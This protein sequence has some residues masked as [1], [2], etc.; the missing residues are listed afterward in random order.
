MNLNF[1]TTHLHF[2]NPLSLDFLLTNMGFF[3]RGQ[4]ERRQGNTHVIFTKELVFWRL[5]PQSN[6]FSP[7][8]IRLLVSSCLVYSD[9]LQKDKKN[10]MQ[11]S[12]IILGY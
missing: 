4:R 7:D 8:F 1:Q 11:T 9:V 2:L 12:T 10:D 3:V 6:I 5:F